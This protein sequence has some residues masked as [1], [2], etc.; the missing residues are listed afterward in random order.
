MGPYDTMRRT[1]TPVVEYSRMARALGTGFIIEP[2]P[3]PAGI[4]SYNSM[5]LRPLHRKVSS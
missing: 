3:E 5:Q 1:I 4:L 2:F